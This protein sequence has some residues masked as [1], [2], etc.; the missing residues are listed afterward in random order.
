[1]PSTANFR[2]SKS[3][4]KHH[5]VC[6][7]RIKVYSDLGAVEE[8]NKPALVHPLLAVAKE[9]RKVRLCL[10]LSR[11]CNDYIR[12]RSF[13]LLSLREA[14]LLSHPGCFYGKMD[15]SACFLSFPLH[16]DASKLMGFSLGG[17]TYRFSGVPFGLSSAPRVV[18]LLL[19]VVSAVLLDR[20]VEHVRYLDDFLFVG[21]SASQVSANMR[22]AALVLQE[23]GLVNNL[24]KC[25]GPARS[26]EFLGIQIDSS[27]CTLSVPKHKLQTLASKLEDVLGRRSVSAQRLRSVLGY[28]SHLSM[29][30][31]AA[32]PFLRGLIDE[33][34]CRRSW[35]KGSRRISKTLRED[36][37]FWLRHAK[38]W[39]G[40]Q[41][42]RAESEPVVLAS[43]ASTSGFGW[44]LERAP[45]SVC[46]RL[47]AFM[48][49]GHA[50][51]GYWDRDLRVLQSSSSN[52]GWGELFVPLAA[53]RRMGPA[54]SN[55]HIVFAIDNAGDVEVINRR[56]TS[57]PRMRTLL[58]ELC[59][60]SLQYNFAF[61]AI[62]RPGAR[63]ILPDILS[64]VELHCHDFRISSISNK[65]LEK[66]AEDEVSKRTAP[67]PKSF[68]FG[69]FFLLDP[70]SKS[71][72]S[73]PLLFPLGISV[74]SSS[75]ASLKKRTAGA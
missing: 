29:V 23:F 43:D 32:R 1:M 71:V 19:D 56:R 9:G 38:S 45:Q 28:L 48:S 34:S 22:T 24:S 66:I 49:P 54:L 26:I 10:D 69:S 5:S 17:K 3:V 64:R 31:P 60:L 40:T 62:H 8:D 36:L 75:S 67:D 41:R 46:D 58:R 18:S 57:S 72:T 6:M 63:N 16:P 13:R 53:V 44:V 2:N 30:L 25:E 74:L 68:A 50:V 55:S 4:D 70:V 21:P 39:N 11:N 33:V 35:L 51:A 15:L 37:L 14:V 20:G 73:T 65:V 52:I 12:K 59:T 27:S 42:W 7:E 47:P 61:T